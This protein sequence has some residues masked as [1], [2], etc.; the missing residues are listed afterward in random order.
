[1]VGIKL[2]SRIILDG[3]CT[4]KRAIQK[5]EPARETIAVIKGVVVEKVTVISK[6]RCGRNMLQGR[7][8][9]HVF[10]LFHS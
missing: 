2:L 6:Q 8:L 10:S 1:M 5:H 4:N 3:C 9:V 7:N